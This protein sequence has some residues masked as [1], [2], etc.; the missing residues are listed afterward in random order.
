VTCIVGLAEQGKVWIGGDSAGIDGWNL[1]VRADPKVIRNGD[2]I[3]GF[4]SS[5]RMGQLLAHKFIPPRRHPGKDVFA[6]MVSD[7]IDAVR[8]CFKTAGYARKDSE[9]E[10]A[11]T[12]LVGYQGRLFT[13]DSDYQ[14]A[15]DAIGFSAC[16][17]GAQVALGAMY[18][19]QS[20]SLD[21]K[22]RVTN[23]LKASER[24]CAGVRGPFVVEAS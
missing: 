2:F 12:F 17:C 19:S 9:Q 11:G 5:F 14:V 4:T 13:V 16:G 18:A 7:F 20:A 22:D 3:F 24:F 23:A 6:F 21:A 1:Q 15:E 8:E 10:T